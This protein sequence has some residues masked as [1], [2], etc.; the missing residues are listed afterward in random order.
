MGSRKLGSGGDFVASSRRHGGIP[1]DR[2]KPLLLR[3]APWILMPL[4]LSTLAFS[5]VMLLERDSGGVGFVPGY[6]PA[7]IL[8]IAM[9]VILSLMLVGG[10]YGLYKDQLWARWVLTVGVFLLLFPGALAA[11]VITSPTSAFPV[12]RGAV[13]T[14]PYLAFAAWYLFMKR[15]VRE[16]HAELKG[17]A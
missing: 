14:L 15:T 8:S 1:T 16:Y 10:G 13:A 7:E 4:G 9:G 2:R 5:G 17:H 6:V 11:L 3:I 12:F